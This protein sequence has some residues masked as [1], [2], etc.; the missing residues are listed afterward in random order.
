MAEEKAKHKIEFIPMNIVDDGKQL[1]VRIPT[2]IV[3]ALDIKPEKDAF[4]FLFDKKLLNLQ[5]VLINKE[6][7]D[8]IK[9]EK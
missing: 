4:L 3:D 6:D 9:N 8:K 7:I 5:G 2:K 1:S